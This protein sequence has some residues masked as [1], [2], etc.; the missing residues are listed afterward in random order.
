MADELLSHRAFAALVGCSNVWVSKQVKSGK[1]PTDASGKI[2][3][4]AGLVAFQAAQV[5][6]YDANRAHAEKQREQSKKIAA[7][8]G[9]ASVSGA[10]AQQSKAQPARSVTKAAPV[11]PPLELPD[12]DSDGMPLAAPPVGPGSAAH[13]SSAKVAEQF[14]KARTAEK[15]FQ[16]KLRELEFKEKQGDLLKITEVE[17]DA[18]AT[19]AEL[20]DKL[21]SLPPRIAGLCE[22]RPAREIEGIIDAE[23]ND[24][25][26]TLQK[27]RFA[28]GA[29]AEG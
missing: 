7:S 10:K 13:L 21:R 26:A 5:V 4:A 24:A 15:M 16:A 6:G 19:A 25:L 14:N 17:I 20:M 1:L 27:S 18:Q 11:Q 22:G 8:A 23:I 29:L 12:E 9:G 3:K 2:P 28:R